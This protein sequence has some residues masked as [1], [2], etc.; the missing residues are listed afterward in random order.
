MGPEQEWIRRTQKYQFLDLSITSPL[1]SGRCEWRALQNKFGSDHYPISIHII[2]DKKHNDNRQDEMEDIRWSFRNMNWTLFSGECEKMFHREN[3]KNVSEDPTELYLHFISTITEVIQK[4]Y[5]K[6]GKR[7]RKPIPWWNKEC[8]DK[9]KERNRAKKKLNRTISIENLNDFLK[10][11]AETQK[12]LRQCE[13]LYWNNFCQKLNRFV[14]ES[15][16]WKCIKRLNGIQTKTK[17]IPVLK[18]KERIMQSDQDKAELLGG[19]FHT[20]FTTEAP[21]STEKTR[22]WQPNQEI[23]DNTLKESKVH[24]LNGAFGLKRLLEKTEYRIQFTKTC[25]LWRESTYYISLI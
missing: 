2:L 22:S 16:I 11:K 18:D 8:S 10:K 24:T 12:F 13:Q 25:P 7:Q 19:F 4:T 3:E 5:P 14:P 23:K 1:L 15:N 20:I 6:K 17:R 21:K 9:I